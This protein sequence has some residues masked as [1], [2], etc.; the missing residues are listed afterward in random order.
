[1]GS[2][3]FG[4]PFNR[5]SRIIYKKESGRWLPN[6]QALFLLKKTRQCSLLNFLLQENFLIV[7][8]RSFQKEQILIKIW[9][10]WE[11]EN[12]DFA[13]RMLRS[14]K[15]LKSFNNDPYLLNPHM[16]DYYI[17]QLNFILRIAHQHKGQC[18]SWGLMILSRNHIRWKVLQKPFME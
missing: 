4:T 7:I 17:H 2:G 12:T 1:M 6:I 8:Q 9:Y 10:A 5:L 15:I 14:W 13:Y 18:L 16:T 3:I 11:G